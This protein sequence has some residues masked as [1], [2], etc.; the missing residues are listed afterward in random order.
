MGLLVGMDELGLRA[1]SMLLILNCGLMGRHMLFPMMEMCGAS[2]FP[3][4]VLGV[5]NALSEVV[6]E[7]DTVV[8]FIEAVR[9]FEC[10]RAPDSVSSEIQ[11]TILQ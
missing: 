5:W 7:G 11:H 2:F 8:V 1:V 10:I 9:C 6:V 3:P 4:R